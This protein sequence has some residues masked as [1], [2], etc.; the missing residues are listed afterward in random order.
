MKI[1]HIIIIAVLGAL[2]FAIGA[3]AS[4]IPKEGDFAVMRQTQSYMPLMATPTITLNA[5]ATLITPRNIEFRSYNPTTKKLTTCFHYTKSLITNKTTCY[6][7]VV[8]STGTTLR[9]AGQG[10]LQQSTASLDKF[11]KVIFEFDRVKTTDGRVGT[12]LFGDTS[13]ILGLDGWYGWYVKYD[14]GVIAKFLRKATT[15]VEVVGKI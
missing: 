9:S 12:V 11:G 13:E 5:T 7:K 14:D 6:Y 2:L 4:Y 1:K 15:D 3:F 10:N 8:T